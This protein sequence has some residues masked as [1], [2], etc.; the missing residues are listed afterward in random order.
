MPDKR[1]KAYNGDKPYIF[2]SYAHKNG[3]SVFPII[4]RLQSQGYRVWYDE[5]IDPGTEWDENIATHVK[6]CGYFLAFIT[7][8]Y[9]ASDNC[10]DELNYARDLNKERVLVYLEPTEL[11]DGMSMRLNRL[12]AIHKYTYTNE[13]LFFDKLFSTD[14]IDACHSGAENVKVIK[15]EDFPAPRRPIGSNL[16]TI[17]NVCSIGSND[18]DDCW[19]KGHYSD[20]INRDQYRIVY[21]HIDVAP[22]KN[23]SKV[24]TGIAVYDDYNNQVYRDE[25]DLNWAPEYTRIAKSWTIRESDGYYVKSGVYRIEFWVENS[26]VYEHKIKIMSNNEDFNTEVPPKKEPKK[27][28]LTSAEYIDITA[29][30]SNLKKKLAAPKGFKLAAFTGLSFLLM[31]M[32]SALTGGFV[33]LVGFILFVFCVLKW[34]KHTKDNVW[35]SWIG[36]GILCLVGGVYF[37]IYLLVITVMH[38]TQGDKWKKELEELNEKLS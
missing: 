37:G 16:A 10:K 21:F 15:E 28:E 20:T 8:Q 13:D 12:Q 31:T 7:P 6:K 24:H 35:D 9:I 2:I 11:P 32:G 23:K 14:G 3:N 36:A 1:A 29:K 30:I 19:P 22:I 38:S 17:R 26:R 25:S 27:P 34:M 5:G 4:E 18:P 33:G